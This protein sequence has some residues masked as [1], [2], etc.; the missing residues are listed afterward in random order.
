MVS[1]TPGPY[2]LSGVRI[3]DCTEFLAG[4]YCTWVLAQLG[5]E[6]IKVERPGG[7]AMR[8]RTLGTGEPV[9]F[10]MVHGNKLSVEAD[11][12]TT[13]GQEAVRRL[14][15]TSDVFVENFR[16]GVAERLGLGQ[17]V[18]RDDNACLVYCSV[19]G[20]RE[21]TVYEGLAGVDPVAEALG[22][23]ASVTGEPDGAPNKAGFPIADVGTG[24]WAAI[25]ILAAL[26]RRG[27]TGTGDYVQSNLLDSVLSWSAWPMSYYLMTGQNPPR[28]GSAHLYLAPFE[29]FQCRDDRYVV[30]G[31]GSDH[32]WR[33]FCAIIR[34]EDLLED[35]RFAELY[36]RGRQASAL[37]EILRPIFL[38][39]DADSWVDRIQA[40]GIPTAVISTMEDIAQSEYVR[41]A[42][43]LP[44][45]EGFAGE[46]RVL[47]FPVTFRSGSLP[48]PTAGP[49]LDSDAH[50]LTE[51][52]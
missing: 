34:R 6:V 48:T 36:E 7:D 32:H 43:M 5:A 12:K 42:D 8:R 38:E 3:V 14:A 28:L 47:G 45:V 29:F 37:R 30:V 4:P 33:K 31:I 51:A 49:A 27:T 1:S 15:A 46:T 17:A 10:H 52:D 9:P 2:L 39:D 11:L 16:P 23:L 19:R 44:T 18:L 20:F 22:G 24:M 21:G 25:G 40:L 41:Q 26:V 35:E 50:L 13:Q